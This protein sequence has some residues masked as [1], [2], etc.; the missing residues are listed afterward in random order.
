[1]ENFFRR[2]IEREREVHYLPDKMKWKVFE[3]SIK[4]T[5]RNIFLLNFS[6]NYL[7]WKQSYELV[8][9]TF[10][11]YVLYAIASE[12]NLN[13]PSSHYLNLIIMLRCRGI[14]YIVALHELLL[15]LSCSSMTGCDA[16]TC[17]LCVNGVIDTRRP[18]TPSEW[19]PRAWG[20]R[21]NVVE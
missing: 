15:S 18:D 4:T 12:Y 19:Y 10:P 8:P 11:I 16:Y 1:M 13:E 21:Y 6:F 5:V 17:Q 20:S 3:I 7:C 9:P 2:A 14:S